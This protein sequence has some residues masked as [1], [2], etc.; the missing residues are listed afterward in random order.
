[1]R[2]FVQFNKQRLPALKD[3]C[4]AVAD[5]ISTLESA[6]EKAREGLKRIRVSAFQESYREPHNFIRD[7]K[8]AA[9]ESLAAIERITSRPLTPRS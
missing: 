9:H 8:T 6:L 4:V 2:E 5:D 7:I 1:M 3:F